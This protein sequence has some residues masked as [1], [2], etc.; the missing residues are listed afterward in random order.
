M[1]YEMSSAT[2]IDAQ[3]QSH[4][5][6][7]IQTAATQ[8]KQLHQLLL[9][10]QKAL[11]QEDYETLEPLIKAKF[12]ASQRMDT[13]EQQRQQL[14]RR[15]GLDAEAATMNRLLEQVTRLQPQS[16]LPKQWRG[17]LERLQQCADQNRINGVLMEGQRRHIQGSLNLLLGQSGDESLYD[18][19][20]STAVTHRHRSVGV[21]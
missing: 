8:A 19:A 4:L 20:G 9:S 1:T 17:L 13:I 14:L 2:M 7:L 16:L 3:T 18:A 15:A 6:E 21:V 10:E 12:K 5:T 11:Q